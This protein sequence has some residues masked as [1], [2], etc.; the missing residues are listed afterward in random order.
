MATSMRF[1]FF[2]HAVNPVVSVV[3][4]SRFGGRLAGAVALLTYRG[5]V[6]GR[7][8]TLPVQWAK[9]PSGC[10]VI[11]VGEAEQKTWW[12]N[13]RIAAPVRLRLAGGQVTGTGVVL[14]DAEEAAAA[15]DAYC[16]RFPAAARSLGPA[17][18]PDGTFAPGAFIEAARRQTVVRVCPTSG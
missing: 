11:V 10:Y 12:R 16:A 18:Q 9:D 7:E 3:L 5:Q 13:L 2:N 4:F 1:R 6:S 8:R 17:R 15:L 14:A